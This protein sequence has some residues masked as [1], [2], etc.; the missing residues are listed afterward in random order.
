MTTA[1]GAGF[2]PYY[3]A[4]PLL[5]ISGQIVSSQRGRAL[6]LEFVADTEGC[7]QG[8]PDRSQ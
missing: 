1:M 5:L 8:S 4:I 2:P 7:H 6:E 3:V